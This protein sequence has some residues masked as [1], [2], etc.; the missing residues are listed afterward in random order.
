MYTGLQTI[1]GQTYLF[2]ASGKMM[3]GWQVIGVQK[4][5]FGPDGA[6]MKG[7]IND[8]TGLYYLDMADGHLLTNTVVTVDNVVYV[9]DAN[10]A[11]IAA[12]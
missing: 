6:L 7:I 11:M 3:T 8:G 12:Q 4:F 2:D 5:Y 9:I 10:G 1:G